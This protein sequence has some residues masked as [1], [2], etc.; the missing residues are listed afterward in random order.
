MHEY[1]VPKVAQFDTRRARARVAKQ[2]LELHIAMQDAQAM[3]VA[4]VRV[5]RRRERTGQE[6]EAS[7]RMSVPQTRRAVQG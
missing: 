3:K 1:R 7:V 2:V 5:K 6:A 4:A